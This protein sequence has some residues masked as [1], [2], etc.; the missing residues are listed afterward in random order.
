MIDSRRDLLYRLL[1]C[2]IKKQELF[3]GSGDISLR[4]PLTQK[5]IAKDL[6]VSPSTINRVK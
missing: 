1:Q 5:Q 3:I 6:G 2:I 4:V